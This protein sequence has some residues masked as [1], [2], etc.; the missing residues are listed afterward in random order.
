MTDVEW[1]AI[2]VE[3][4]WLDIEPVILEAMREAYVLGRDRAYEESARPF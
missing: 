2:C 4:C 3:Q 1:R